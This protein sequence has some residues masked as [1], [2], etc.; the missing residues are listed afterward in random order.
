MIATSSK[1]SFL[2]TFRFFH[3]GLL[4]ATENSWRFGPTKSPHQQDKM[5]QLLDYFNNKHV[6]RGGGDVSKESKFGW[7]TGSDK[8]PGRFI[9]P[10]RT[11]RDHHPVSRL[12]KSAK[13]P[14]SIIGYIPIVVIPEK[15]EKVQLIMTSRWDLI[16]LYIYLRMTMY[17]YIYNYILYIYIYH[18]IYNYIYIIIYDLSH[19]ISSSLHRFGGMVKPPVDQTR[20]PGF[21]A[22]R[23]SAWRD[24]GIYHGFP[25]GNPM[26]NGIPKHVI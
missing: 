16:C 6:S 22:M 26:S 4:E 1:H 20:Q 2:W 13:A 23:S 9:M 8:E 21:L 25:M 19:C 15:L 17:R 3:L 11:S 24:H 7:R 12:A 18:Y 10:F 5:F 14:T